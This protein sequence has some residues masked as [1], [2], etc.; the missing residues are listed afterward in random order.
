MTITLDAATEERLQSEMRRGGYA[1]AAD[2]IR[3]ALDRMQEPEEDGEAWKLYFADTLERRSANVDRGVF[4]SAE[5]A[6]AR[7]TDMRAARVK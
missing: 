4:Y 3:A 6:K 2:L 7:L 5:E 1:S